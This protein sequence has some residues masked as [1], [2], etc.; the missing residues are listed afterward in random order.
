MS[1]ILPNV[2]SSGPG[3]SQT[4]RQKREVS[5]D[6]AD[7]GYESSAEMDVDYDDVYE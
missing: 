7:E 2:F 1:S 3:Q 4:T 6:A 5:T